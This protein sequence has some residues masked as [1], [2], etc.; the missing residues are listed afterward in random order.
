MNLHNTNI[1]VKLIKIMNEKG[2]HT[3]FD[4]SSKTEGEL[5]RSLPINIK[6]LRLIKKE[7]QL[8][9][10]DTQGDPI[11]SS[12]EFPMT[13][14]RNII[15]HDEIEAFLQELLNNFKYAENSKEFILT[16][17]K[18]FLYQKSEIEPAI[19]TEPLSYPGPYHKVILHK[20]LLNN[21]IQAIRTLKHDFA[22]FPRISLD[23]F[24][25]PGLKY[26]G[27]DSNF[28]CYHATTSDSNIFL[29]NT[30][31]NCLKDSNKYTAID[32]QIFVMISKKTGEFVSVCEV[33]SKVLIQNLGPWNRELTELEFSETTSLL[34]DKNLLKYDQLSL[35]ELTRFLF[36]IKIILLAMP[37]LNPNIHFR[38]F[39]LSLSSVTLYFITKI[40]PLAAKLPFLRRIFV[41]KI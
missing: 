37:F 36:I 3:I 41:K 33:C 10:L 38:F 15:N 4:L 5:M 18:N 6:M 11:F 19:P 14:L 13:A 21:F 20:S 28:W 24:I 35:L 25:F 23:S 17:V 1:P 22:K 39:I 9:N 31:H 29:G 12:K 30:L 7:L 2:F 32:S 16:N 40:D 26:I 8:H 27:S 34:K